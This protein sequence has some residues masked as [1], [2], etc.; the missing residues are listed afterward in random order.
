MRRAVPSFTVEVRRRPSLATTSN[1]E[2]QSPEIK[3][4]QAGFD[5]ESHRAAAAAF[6]A[7]KTDPSPVD[8]AASQPTGRILPSLASNEEWHRRLED[9]RVSAAD[10]EPPSRGPK[11][12]SVRAR[13]GG[14]QASKSPRNSSFSS[15]GNAPS[16]EW[17][18]TKSHRTSTVRSD[19]EAG[20]SPRDPTRASSRVVG[21]D[22]SLAVSA[23]A[24]RSD[25]I[26][27]THDDVRA[28]TFPDDQR[29]STGM[30]SSATLPSKVDGRSPGSRKRIILTRYVFGDEF[31]P[32]ERWKRQLLTSR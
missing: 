6:D 17:S 24:R 8:V 29:S 21:D 30:E 22:R 11:R 26:A 18:P 7:Q 27:I 10:S 5:R 28:E 23:E 15:D 4:P 14:D 1:P 12:P 25:K 2:A 9:A 16:P 31:K 20:I 32:G 13:N 19:E 3:P